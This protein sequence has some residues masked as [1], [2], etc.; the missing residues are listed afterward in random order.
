MESNSPTVLR[1]GLVEQNLGF[2]DLPGGAAV[3][4]AWALGP[5][6]YPLPPHLTVVAWI[7]TGPYIKVKVSVYSIDFCLATT[8]I[9]KKG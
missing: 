1:L 2:E 5:A 9:P 8:K 6:R 4:A 3:S 7:P